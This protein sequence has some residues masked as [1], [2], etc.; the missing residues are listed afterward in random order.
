MTVEGD[1]LDGFYQAMPPR[2]RTHIAQKPLQVMRRLVRI[3]PAGGVVLDP[4]MGSGTTGVAAVLEGR[5]FTGC[6]NTAHFQQ[7]A[8]ERIEGAQ[9]GYRARGEQGVLTAHEPAEEVTA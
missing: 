5:A 2:D 1:C 7:E 6:E 9:L 4:F 8:R 3:A